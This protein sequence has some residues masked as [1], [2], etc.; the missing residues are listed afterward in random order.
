MAQGQRGPG[1]EGWVARWYEKSTQKY[2]REFRELADE[3]ASRLPKGSAVLEIAPGPGYL[4]VELAKRGLDVT[5]LDIS[6]TFIE[7]CRGRAAAAGVSARFVEGDAAQMPFAES[8]FDFLICRAAFKNFSDPQ[9]ALREMW[10]V[11]RP[12]ADGLIIDLRRDAR[13]SD[14]V[15]NIYGTHS[16][17]FERLS[18]RMIFSTLRKRAYTPAEIERML[19]QIPFSHT[20][21]EADTI[22]MNVRLHR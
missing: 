20:S 16:S 5:A 15:A 13:M 14:I 10:R 9:G 12:D 18:G 3:I 2:D 8:S 22:G 17:I 19:A 7:L 4:S 21:V 6:K 11:L 1:M